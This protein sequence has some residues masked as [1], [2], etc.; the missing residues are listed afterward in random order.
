MDLGSLRCDVNFSIMPEGS[1]VFGTRTEFKNLNSIRS[2]G[3]AIE[4]EYSRQKR[5]IEKGEKVIQQTL[6]WNDAA[7]VTTALRS[8]EEAHDYRYFPEPDIPP[9]FITDE[10]IED[11]KAKMPEMPDSRKARYID[12]GLTEADASL[13]IADKTLSDYF[14]KAIAGYNNPKSVASMILV[15][16]LRRMNDASISAEEI[17]ILPED[18]ATLCKMADEGTVSRGA[19]KDILREMFEKGGKPMDI[20]EKLGMIMSNDT[21]AVEAAAD[22]ILAANP[23]AVEEYKGGSGKVFGFLMGQMCRTLG[24]SANPA[25]I[26]KVLEEKL[27]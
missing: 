11:I 14:E 18:L 3:R 23:K 26:K 20:A 25:I 15:E 5:L 9:I 12:F 10:E 27:K 22:E 8:K 1:D 16:L 2:V 13:L 4:Y 24:K 21:S 6:H 19:A 7:G 17:E